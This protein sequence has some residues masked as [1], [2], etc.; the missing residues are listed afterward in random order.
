MAKELTQALGQTFMVDNKPGG[1]S[2]I[3]TDL[4][5]PP[6]PMATPCCLWP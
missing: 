1:G 4:W 2:N 3:A 5:P 6:R